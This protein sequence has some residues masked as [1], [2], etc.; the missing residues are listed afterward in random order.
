MKKLNFIYVF[1]LC[2]FL[3]L[4]C[5]NESTNNKKIIDAQK[6]INTNKIGQDELNAEGIAKE[7]YMRGIVAMESE[8]TLVQA[9]SEFTCA[10]KYSDNYK[11]KAL[12]NL[13]QVY[14]ELKDSVAYK[15]HALLLEQLDTNK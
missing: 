10:M 9:V 12:K 14:Q 7:C 13:V 15:K 5:K 1:I 8:K 4:S 6:S 11:V 2:L 3:A